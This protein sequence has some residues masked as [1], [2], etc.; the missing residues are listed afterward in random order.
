MYVRT[1][2]PP[3]KSHK[4]P[5]VS[6]SYTYIYMCVYVC[7]YVLPWTSTLAFLKVHLTFHIEIQQ[8]TGFLNNKIQWLVVHACAELERQTPQA[9][10]TQWEN[11]I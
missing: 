1:L 3:V 7:I 10:Y 6:F 5:D 2:F 8:Q 4:I 11:I 9:K